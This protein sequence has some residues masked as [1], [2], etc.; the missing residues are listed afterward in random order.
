MKIRYIIIAGA[1]FIFAIFG[2]SR[3]LLGASDDE[4]ANI[5]FTLILGTNEGDKEYADKEIKEIADGLRKNRITNF[6]IYKVIS[7]YRSKEDFGTKVKFDFSTRLENYRLEI[8]PELVETDGGERVLLK[9]EVFEKAKRASGKDK[10][11]FRDSPK[12][13]RKKS[14]IYFSTP[15]DNNGSLIFLIISV[16]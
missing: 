8:T 6:K 10:S 4:K 14:C 1:F 11:I 15:Y 3:N 12:V 9:G 16:Y 13:A 2:A 7:A 5:K